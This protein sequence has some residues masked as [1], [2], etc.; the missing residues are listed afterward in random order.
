MSQV[1]H[2]TCFSSQHR[3]LRVLFSPLPP[4]SQLCPLHRTSLCRAVTSMALPDKAVM[5]GIQRKVTGSVPQPPNPLAFTAPCRPNEL[6]SLIL[7]ETLH[8]VTPKCL[9]K[10]FK[11]QSCLPARLFTVSKTHPG[12]RRQSSD[13][14]GWCVGHRIGMSECTLNI[15]GWDGQ[16]PQALTPQSKSRRLSCRLRWL[17]AKREGERSKYQVKGCLKRSLQWSDSWLSLN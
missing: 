12:F 10:Q 17:R 16:S 15:S 8:I 13:I 6:N 1:Q 2:C 9:G 7:P 5:L 11:I 14:N 4:K 3:S